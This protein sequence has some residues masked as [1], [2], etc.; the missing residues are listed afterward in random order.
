M[1]GSKSGSNSGHR[2]NVTALTQ[3][4]KRQL[5][6]RKRNDGVALLYERCDAAAVGGHGDGE[7]QAANELGMRCQ[8]ALRSGGR[9]GD[10]SIIFS[11]PFRASAPLIRTLEW[12]HLSLA[13]GH[14]PELQPNTTEMARETQPTNC[15]AEQLRSPK[16]HSLVREKS[17]PGFCET[18]V[19]RAI[20][21]ISGEGVKVWIDAVKAQ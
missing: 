9:L 6:Q 20:F 7:T 21:G 13:R 10:P 5:R 16:R 19:I 2:I 15:P 8:A 1:G 4:G 12:P 3:R 14:A 18:T 11:S 17:R